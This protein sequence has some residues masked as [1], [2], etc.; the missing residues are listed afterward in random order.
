M[1]LGRAGR[2]PGAPGSAPSF[3]AARPIRCSL[4]GVGS[5]LVGFGLC[6]GSRVGTRRLP[7]SWPG[8]GRTCAGESARGWCCLRFLTLRGIN[9][10][11]LSVL[12]AS[13]A[14]ASTAGASAGEAVACSA[15]DAA[16]RADGGA[17]VPKRKQV[18]APLCFLLTQGPRPGFLHR[19]RWGETVPSA[20]IPA[21]RARGQGRFSR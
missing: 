7:P 13:T 2:G 3:D 4:P 16:R 12:C 9:M 20:F 1:W 8:A 10:I 6:P 14:G 18:I 5:G 11:Q 17:P 19:R 15:L 21:Q